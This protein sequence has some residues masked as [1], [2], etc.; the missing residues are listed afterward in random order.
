MNEIIIL[1]IKHPDE[2]LKIKT[3]LPKGSRCNSTLKGGEIMSEK[4]KKVIETFKKVFP[5]MTEL[6]KEKLQS[7]GEGLAFAIQHTEAE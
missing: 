6:Q 7:F 2:S 3:K 5:K 1:E 4:E